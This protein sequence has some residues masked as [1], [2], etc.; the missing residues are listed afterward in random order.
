[1]PKPTDQP[2]SNTWPK[3]AVS[4]VIL[5][6]NE[7]DNLTECLATCGWCDD[8]HVLDS[9]ST[10][11]TVRIAEQAGVS[12]HTNTFENFAQQRNWAT[13][14]I[15]CKNNWVFHLDADERFTPEL[16]AELEST[17]NNEPKVDGFHVAHKMML[18]GTWLKRSEGYPVYQ[19]RLIHKSRFRYI[20]SGHGQRE[21]PGAQMGTLKE[22]YLHEAYRR[23]PEAQK[24]GSPDT[25]HTA[26]KKQTPSSAVRA[27]R[28][29]GQ[30]YS[31]PTAPAAG[32]P[33]KP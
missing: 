32:A 28:S 18:A 17:I 10:D 1:M 24:I 30:T 8:V 4:V 7:E 16:V 2:D 13:D 9:G 12:V 23:G 22:P 19:A 21:S 25:T 15:T 5:T 33:S 31:A 27:S 3:A 20:A 14:H 29:T 11:A 6:L 26:A